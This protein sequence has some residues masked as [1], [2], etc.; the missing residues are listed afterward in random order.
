MRSKN[1]TS[2]HSPQD[3]VLEL[4][5]FSLMERQSTSNSGGVN[6]QQQCLQPPECVTT[7]TQPAQACGAGGVPAGNTS[8]CCFKLGRHPWVRVTLFIFVLAAVVLAIAL[9]LGLN[10]TAAA[11][12]D[13]AKMQPPQQSLGPRLNTSG[14]ALVFA[15]DFTHFD[16]DTWNVEMGDGSDYGLD[17]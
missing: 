16:G 14:M 5:M 9:P 11:A 15:D 4:M 12:A 6:K 10:R 7:V 3:P 1:G 8:S 13:K 17:R 2:R